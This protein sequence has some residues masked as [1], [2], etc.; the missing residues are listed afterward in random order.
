MENRPIPADDDAFLVAIRDGMK[1]RGWN[2]KTLA[3]EAGKLREDGDFKGRPYS[4]QAM[5]KLLSHG[6]GGI[7]MKTNVAAA[8]G[9]ITYG[10]ALERGREIL[11]NKTQKAET[12]R[13]DDKMP[14]DANWIKSIEKRVDFLESMFR[15]HVKA[16][17]KPSDFDFKKTA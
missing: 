4:Q 14:V 10:A 7:T 16:H 9:I 5:T 17:G 1:N 3:R 6:E 13:E 2:N 15:E 8:V 11:Q 12:D